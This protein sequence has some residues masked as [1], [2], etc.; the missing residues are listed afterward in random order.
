M[1]ATVLLLEPD[2][3]TRGLLAEHLAEDGWHVYEC[4]ADVPN[5]GKPDVVIALAENGEIRFPFSDVP[6]VAML[7]GEGDRRAYDTLIRRGVARV[8]VKP[9]HYGEL[10]GLLQERRDWSAPAQV[11]ADAQAHPLS[12]RSPRC[13]NPECKGDDIRE[14]VLVPTPQDVK[15]ISPNGEVEYG[16]VGAGS[17]DAGETDEWRCRT[18]DYAS[19]DP[20]D[21]Y[22]WANDRERAESLLDVAVQALDGDQFI[23]AE[24]VEDQGKAW[25]CGTDHRGKAVRALPHEVKRVPEVEDV[26]RELLQRAK[27]QA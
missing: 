9:F 22:P 21:F 27:A 4:E 14:W 12:Q 25:V 18:C 1:S 23:V 15:L 7:A 19:D 10:R 3:V 24:V 20:L 8:L 26:L 11:R 5:G 17:F 16:N 6:T 2:D 13:P